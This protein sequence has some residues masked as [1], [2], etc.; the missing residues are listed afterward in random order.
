MTNAQALIPC[1]YLSPS[2]W[3][4]EIHEN[5]PG[6]KVVLAA[7]KCDLRSDKVVTERLE[8]HGEEP[9]TYEQGIEV[10][11]SRLIVPREAS[12]L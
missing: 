10:S 5:C 4:K 8:R 12:C 6:V 3:I 11:P 1:V 7:L 9:V 2:Q